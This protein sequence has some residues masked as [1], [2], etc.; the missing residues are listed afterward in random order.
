M[1]QMLKQRGDIRR[2]CPL[3]PSARAKSRWI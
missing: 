2:E 1:V 3:A